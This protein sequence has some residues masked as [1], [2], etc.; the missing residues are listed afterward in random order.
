MN[1]VKVTEALPPLKAVN[2]Y[3][4]SEYFES[5]LVLCAYLHHAKIHYEIVIYTK[6]R[7]LETAEFWESWYIPAAEDV[8]QSDVIAWAEFPAFEL[9]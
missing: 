9:A 3:S 7:Y 4:E 8:L 5:D 1:W 2:G 6:G